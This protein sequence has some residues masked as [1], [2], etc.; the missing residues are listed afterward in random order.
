[1]AATRKR[2]TRVVAGGQEPG[3]IPAATR[4]LELEPRSRAHIHAPISVADMEGCASGCDD[5][6]GHTS[7][8][9][10]SGARFHPSSHTYARIGAAMPG[11]NPRLDISR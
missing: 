10:G 1:V 4:T 3:F 11:T 8:R 9:G 5:K 7:G 6:E 2:G